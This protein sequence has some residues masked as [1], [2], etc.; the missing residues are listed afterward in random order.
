MNEAHAKVRNR[1]DYIV[2]QVAG[3]SLILI[4]SKGSHLYA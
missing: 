2:C 4:R 3:A 1:G